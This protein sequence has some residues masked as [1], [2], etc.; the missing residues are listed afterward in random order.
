MRSQSQTQLNNFHFLSLQD[1]PGCAVDKNLPANARDM[2]LI[3]GPEDFHMPW[4]NQ[5]Y[6]ISPLR[7]ASCF[8]LLLDQPVFI[9][10]L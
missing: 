2:G 9:F 1:F 5:F 3:P 6:L 7:I 10:T 4:S 8:Q